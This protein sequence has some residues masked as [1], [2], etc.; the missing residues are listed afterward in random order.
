[1]LLVL[2]NNELEAERQ[3]TDGELN[4]VRK[5]ILALKEQSYQAK[6]DERTRVVGQL[7]QIPSAK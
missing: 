3:K 2:T 7:A 4:E 1:M 5:Q 6:D